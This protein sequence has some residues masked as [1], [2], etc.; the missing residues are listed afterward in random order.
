MDLQ[1]KP[2][3]PTGQ[4]SRKVM[5]P[6]DYNIINC[7]EFFDRIF[8]DDSVSKDFW[9]AKMQANKL[10]KLSLIFDECCGDNNYGY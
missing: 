7:N 1:G 8:S 9:E 3:Y 10:V 6:V 5:E 2:N 4:E